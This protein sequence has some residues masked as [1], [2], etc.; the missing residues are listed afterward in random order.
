M[1]NFSFDV[2]SEL[3]KSE[4]NNV[5]DQVAREITSRYDFKNTPAAIDWLNDQRSGFKLTGNSDYQIDAILDV[6]RKKLSL[7][8]QSQFVI[9]TTKDRVTTNLKVVLEVPFK[10]G[11]DQTKTKQLGALLRENLPKIKSVIQ[12]ETLRVSGPS[13]N[14]LQSAITLIKSQ[15]LDYPVQFIN[16]R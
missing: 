1:A 7:R 12:G 5:F 14:D 15:D 6:I 9:D 13:K 8:G 11:L 2:V 10:Q 3:D 16:Y 4:L